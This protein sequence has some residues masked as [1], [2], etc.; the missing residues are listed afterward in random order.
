MAVA[1]L[2]ATEVR[3]TGTVKTAPP[4]EVTRLDVRVTTEEVMKV[5]VD[6]EVEDVVV[7]VEEEV[8]V[9]EVSEV[10]EVLDLRNDDADRYGHY[11]HSG[12][13]DIFIC[14]SRRELD[15]RL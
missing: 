4:E 15:F 6:V 12:C 2:V 10:V 11:V 3:V 9:V 13:V 7:E 1:V 5:E 8:E 14:D